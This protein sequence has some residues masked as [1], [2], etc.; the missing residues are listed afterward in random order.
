MKKLML[1]AVQVVITTTLYLLGGLII[2]LALFPVF[3]LMSHLMVSLSVMTTMKQLFL[4]ALAIGMSYFIFGLS[5]MMIVGLLNLILQIKLKV[6]VYGVGHPESIKWF[7]VN[8]LFLAVRTVFMDFMLLTPFC[9]LFFR[10]MGA[11]LGIG[12]QINSKNVADLSLL[13]IGDHS[14]IGGN[15]TVICHLFEAKGLVLMP[16]T[17][18][19]RVVIGL[20]S[21]IMPGCE[22]G[23]D[24]VIAAGAVV[25][26]KTIIPPKT[27]YYSPDKMVTRV[28]HQSH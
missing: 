5:L 20:N 11:R 13:S 1:V 26:K 9:S 16:V 12:V 2:G 15:A 18:G 6:G 4:M 27:I 24:S 8:A 17:I 19:K 14:V 25:P 28:A 21:V 7:F 22:I 10:M 23:D 3:L